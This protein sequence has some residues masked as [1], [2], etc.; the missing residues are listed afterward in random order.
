MNLTIAQLEAF[1][2][3][4]RLGSVK[5]AA[6]QLNLAQ[7][8]ISLRLKCLQ[9]ELGK[10][11]FER[12]GWGIKLTLE[13]EQLFNHTR[14][15]LDEIGRLRDRIGTS[16][17]VK[18][19]VRVG[20]PETFAVTCLP[21]L[22][23]TIAQDHPALRLELTVSTSSDL[24]REVL[25]RKLELAFVVHPADL[26]SLRLIPLGRQEAVWMASPRFKLGPMVRPADLAHV[27]VITN[28]APSAMYRQ[29]AGWFSAADIEPQ[30]LDICTSVMVIAHLVEEGVA[31]GF[32][33]VKLMSRQVRAG[34]V[35]MLE[36]N[37]V[38]HHASVYAA[39]RIGGAS[40]Q[41]ETVVV[42]ARQVLQDLDFLS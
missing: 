35:E 28:P 5:G 23:Q 9:E 33:P 3:A 40:R 7:P 41:V 22:L 16:E 42:A 14:V 15:V 39:H 34:S 10:R 25:E 31:A 20:V 21:R 30:R 18:G 1:F 13:G 26:T 36:A 37:P 38:L 11:L 19:V 12:S 2:W 4:A 24:E 32:L 8:T 6:R 27:P 17:A 29:I